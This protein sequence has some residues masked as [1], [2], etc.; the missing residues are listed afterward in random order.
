[1]PVYLVLLSQ[2]FQ[3]WRSRH[4][5]FFSFFYVGK[6]TQRSTDWHKVMVWVTAVARNRI[7]ETWLPLPLPLPL[8][9]L[10]RTP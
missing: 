5:F 1:M 3:P 10:S 8:Q 7:Q 6:Q 4:L 2:G 9:T